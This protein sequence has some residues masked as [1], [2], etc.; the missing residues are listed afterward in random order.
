MKN[1]N[2]EYLIWSKAFDEKVKLIGLEELIDRVNEKIEYTL[3]SKKLEVS[4][5]EK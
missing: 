5:D 3:R 1:I 2:S 4:T